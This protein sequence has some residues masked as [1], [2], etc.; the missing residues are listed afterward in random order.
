VAGRNA[1]RSRRPRCH[2]NC[3]KRG[4]RT[5]VIAVSLERARGFE[6]L[7]SSLGNEP[8]APSFR[9]SFDRS[10]CPR[11]PYAIRRQDARRAFSRVDRH[12]STVKRSGNGQET[13]RPIAVPSGG[14]RR[15][16]EYGRGLVGILPHRA[17][18]SRG[19]EAHEH[20]G[21]G[22]QASECQPRGLPPR[23]WPDPPPGSLLRVGHS[24]RGSSA[25]RGSPRER[26]GQ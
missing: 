14:S 6:P 9:S 10:R 19:V 26:L 2:K 21:T 15:R 8:G 22:Q 4:P 16:V 23:L 24:S 20:R 13:V 5:Q 1:A 7:T 17:E 12:P 3:E 25:L 18:M 11:I